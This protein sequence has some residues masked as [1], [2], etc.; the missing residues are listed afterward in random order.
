M[1]RGVSLA[2]LLLT[3]ALM[4]V[5]MAILASLFRAAARSMMHTEQKDVQV[6]GA[7]SGVQHVRQDL[8][9]AI[10]ITT[11]AAGA[12]AD[13]LAMVRLTPF[14]HNY[15]TLPLLAAGSLWQ[16]HPNAYRW[17]V[18]Y[19]L[20]GGA[21]IRDVQPQ[22]GSAFQSTV[23]E[24]L[25]GFSCALLNDPA[26]RPVAARVVLETGSATLLRRVVGE[27]PLHLPRRVV[28]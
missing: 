28:P 24:Q 4:S 21:L 18:G 26:N 25:S 3:L 22:G 5:A 20:S 10:N 23:A 2:E 8:E 1:R 6:R 7:I 11:P 17:T 9:S 12:S 14:A 15:G 16:P 13:T 19:S 27:F